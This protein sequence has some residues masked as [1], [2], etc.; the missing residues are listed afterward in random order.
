MCSPCCSNS[1]LI[2]SQK[3]QLIPRCSSS[4]K[5]RNTRRKSRRRFMTLVLR[6]DFP[7]RTTPYSHYQYGHYAQTSYSHYP[8]YTQQTH[9]AAAQ[10]STS[11]TQTPAPAT[12]PAVASTVIRPITQ[13]T[14]TQTQQSGVDTTDVATL[15]DALGSAGV[16]LRVR[17]FVNQVFRSFPTRNP[18]TSGRR[19]DPSAYK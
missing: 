6:V 2:L 16:D 12:Q 4:L 1:T 17:L 19:R 15:N 13:P 14:Q 7:H 5:C 3:F 9:Q 8:Q 11:Q 18:I 10:A